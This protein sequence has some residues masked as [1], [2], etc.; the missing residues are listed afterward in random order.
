MISTLKKPTSILIKTIGEFIAPPICDVC[1]KKTGDNNADFDFLCIECINSMPFAPN[2]DEIY[3]K[4]IETFPNDDLYLSNA[5]ALI[6]LSENEGYDNLIY[7]LKYYGIYKIG[8]ELGRML[9]HRLANLQINEFDYIV[10]VPIHHAR[11]RERGYNQSFY[12]AMS[13]S[14]ILGIKYLFNTI[15]R[16]RYTQTQ[17]RLNAADRLNNLTGSI[18]AGR[19]YAEIIGKKVLLVDDVLTTGATA[20]T[21]AKALMEIGADNVEAATL[22]VA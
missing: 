12:I 13:I 21:C 14:E 15:R 22:I 18:E 8:V 16:N 3:A 10:P 19:N 9:G 17:T 5:A 20:N 7:S 4:L 2:P 6:S 11:F 1:G